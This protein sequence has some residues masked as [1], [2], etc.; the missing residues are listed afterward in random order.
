MK[1]VFRVDSSSIIG[2]GH[3]VRCV[4]L[5]TELRKR[6]ARCLFICRNLPGNIIDYVMKRKFDVAMLPFNSTSER[7]GS[8]NTDQY[9]EWLGVDW[10][11]DA[12][13]TIAE[14]SGK[15]ID[16]L[17][18]DH[19]GLDSLW[20]IEV[21][22][23][24]ARTMVIDDLANRS[25][26]CDVL[27]DQNFGGD[28]VTKYAQ[29]IDVKATLQLLGPKFSL[30]QDE[31]RLPVNAIETSSDE[32]RILV[33]FG[34][35]DTYRLTLYFANLL[36]AT[37]VDYAEVVV[38]Y[39]TSGADYKELSTMREDW[40]YLTIVEPS[41]SL[42]SEL[43]RATLAIG[44]CGTHAI[45]RLVCNVP[46]LVVTIADNQVSI[47]EYLSSLG[48]IKVLGH[49]ADGITHITNTTIDDSINC[50]RQT[51]SDARRLI[52]LDSL[53]THRVSDVILLSSDVKIS[54]RFVS[55]DDVSTLFR[56]V[57]DPMVRS[58]SLN[59]DYVSLV[60]HTSWFES[61]FN[62]NGRYIAIVET[63]NNIPV[64]QVRIDVVGKT[65]LLDYSVDRIFR[66]KG[67]S[68]SLVRKGIDLILSMVD[69]VVIRAVVKSINVVSQS[70]LL[71]VG[72][73]IACKNHDGSL[74]MEYVKMLKNE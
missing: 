68:K 54:A 53:G 37:S 25:H 33:Y 41:N 11:T 12:H 3:V 43:S 14:L 65:G 48:L 47:A 29:L 9:S 49:A 42:A 17:I 15:K 58:M 24:A 36:K 73:K 46:A 67:L 26:C 70:V 44:A 71:S 34:L 7:Y 69:V 59:S 6:G 35:N 32:E 51:F 52:D 8:E 5:A 66:G 64:G 13:E 45:E 27:L 57:N 61:S 1:V 74:V 30:L 18:V 40:Q 16:W 19:Y 28:E 50:I 10:K 4:T 23:C 60:E 63:Q 2:S 20:E 62:G 31:Y 56:W 38:V 22:H 21:G 39:P 72:F 55:R